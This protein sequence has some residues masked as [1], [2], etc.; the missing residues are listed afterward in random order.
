MD[1]RTTR[2]SELSSYNPRVFYDAT[3]SLLVDDRGVLLGFFR[4]GFG[5]GT[6]ACDESRDDG[7]CP[8]E[9]E[10][11]DS[12]PSRGSSWDDLAR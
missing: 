3:L 8:C 2:C 5:T 11:Y 1:Q 4:R 9:H 6:D 12:R 7:P 10:P